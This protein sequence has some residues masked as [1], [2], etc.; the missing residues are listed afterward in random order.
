MALW[1]R[2]YFH[3]EHPGID[4]SLYDCKDFDAIYKN[5]RTKLHSMEVTK[6]NGPDTHPVL[7]YLKNV[8]KMEDFDGNFAPFFFV[9]PDGNKVEFHRK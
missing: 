9:N 6:I 8:F 5:P 1:F 2:N 4:Y 7:K 3:F